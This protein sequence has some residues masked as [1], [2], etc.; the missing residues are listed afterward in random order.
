MKKIKP[1]TLVKIWNF[2]PPF[3]FSGI[4]IDKVSDDMRYALIKLKLRFYN[5]NYVGTQFGGAM[6]AATDAMYMLMLIHNLGPDYVVWDKTA[7]IDF[8]KP[9]KTDLTA[10]FQITEDDL[11]NIRAETAEKGKMLWKRDVEL[12]D[13]HGVVVAIAE[14]VVYIRDKRK[15]VN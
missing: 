8:L 5:R 11:Q 3:F 7:R 6:F 13:A 1:S 10:E 2:W 4:R 9:G 12:K 14:R 15:P